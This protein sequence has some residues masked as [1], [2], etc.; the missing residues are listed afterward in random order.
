MLG[1]AKTTTGTG[2]RT[3][4]SIPCTSTKILLPNRPTYA[5][6]AK[7]KKKTEIAIVKN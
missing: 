1:E 2:V 3:A 5:N 6:S 4:H 7:Q